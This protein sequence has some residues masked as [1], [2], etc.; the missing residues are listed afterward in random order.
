MRYFALRSYLPLKV[1]PFYK[2]KAAAAEGIDAH[3]VAVLELIIS[4]THARTHI[5]V[6]SRKPT[7]SNISECPQ[8]LFLSLF[9]KVLNSQS[10]SEDVERVSSSDIWSIVEA[11]I[12]QDGPFL[13][14]RLIVIIFYKVFH[15]M[16]IFFSIKN[17]LVMTLNLYRLIV[18]CQDFRPSSSTTQSG[19][20]VLWALWV[21]S[22]ARDVPPR[23][24]QFTKR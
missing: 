1:S 2:H 14:V 20:G 15:Q 16:L 8:P 13:V 9:T 12:I 18:L 24:L 23:D 4:H 21:S 19:S 5:S 22:G 17:L 3:L 7:A 6:K 10:N 11:L